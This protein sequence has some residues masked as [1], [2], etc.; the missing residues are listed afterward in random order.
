[1][2]ASHLLLI[3]EALCDLVADRS[4]RILIIEAPPRHGKSEFASRWF[5]VWYLGMFPTHRVF[6]AAYGATFA[7]EFGAW[8]RD[9]Y[10]ECGPEWFGCGVD[11]A[12]ARADHWKTTEGGAM[13]SCGVGGP[14]NGRGANLFIFDDPIKNAQAAA[15][16]AQ[17]SK[18]W[19]WYKSTASTRLEPDGKMVIINTRWH[20]DDMTG[21]IIKAAHEGDS[22]PV[23]RITLP[24]IAE[25]NDMAGRK[26]G[27]A[28]WPERFP[29]ESLRVKE[30]E[31]GP[32]YWNALYQQRPTSH[33]RAIFRDHYF[34]GIMV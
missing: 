8:A 28:L 25:F 6:F 17:R 33:E 7:E 23:R 13:Y 14:I 11:K 15:S 5:P 1:M 12:K 22:R 30:K 16:E 3:D 2:P 9:K 24:A 31:Q 27:E 20:V 18:M 29:I 32:F 19:N 21:M 26:E 10:A 4:A 34:D